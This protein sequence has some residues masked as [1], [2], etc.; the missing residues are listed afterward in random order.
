M[1]LMIETKEGCCDRVKLETSTV[2][3]LIISKALKL[4]SENPDIHEKDRELA[5]AM[6]DTKPNFYER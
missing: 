5:K 4:L 3:F 1:H 6:V 2:E